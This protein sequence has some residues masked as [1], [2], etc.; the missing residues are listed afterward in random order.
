MIEQYLVSKLDTIE[1]LVGKCYPTAAPVGD[2]GPPFCI[3][4]RVSGTIERD[5]A[6]DPVYYRDVFRLDLFGDDMDA[7]CA[8]EA[9]VIATMTEQCVDAGD[10]LY[11]FN[12]VAAPGAQD[13]FDMAMEIHQRSVAYTVTY[14]R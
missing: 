13:G 4:R 3:Y 10:T 12:A 7:L 8:L 9:A 6:D 1:D 11:I 2:T 14:W 5:L